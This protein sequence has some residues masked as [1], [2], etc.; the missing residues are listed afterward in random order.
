[1]QRIRP[2]ESLL[3]EPRKETTFEEEMETYQKKTANSQTTGPEKAA[4][5]EIVTENAAETGKGSDEEETQSMEEVEQAQDIDQTGTQTTQDVEAVMVQPEEETFEM[6]TEDK[7]RTAVEQMER[8]TDI[9]DKPV[10][11][12]AN[13]PSLDFNIDNDGTSDVPQEASPSSPNH[14]NSKKKAITRQ[15]VLKMSETAVK[16][17]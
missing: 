12:E 9:V 10:V 8:T 1:M 4:V 17:P 5:E 3:S 16:R 6:D 15:E 14:R 7:S 11:N 2:F 13:E